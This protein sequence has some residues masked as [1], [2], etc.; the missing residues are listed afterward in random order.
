MAEY[1][2]RLMTK[3][4][5]GTSGAMGCCT[6]YVE[7]SI[8]DCQMRFVSMLSDDG[9][10]YDEF[11]VELPKLVQKF[12]QSE[13]ITKVD[14]PDKHVSIFNAVREL[15]S[16]AQLAKWAENAIKDEQQGENKKANNQWKAIKAV[17]EHAKTSGVDYCS[18]TRGWENNK[19]AA[20]G[21]QIM[22]LLEKNLQETKNHKIKS[23]IFNLI[24]EEAN[25]GEC[26]LYAIPSNYKSKQNVKYA[27]ENHQEFVN[28]EL[29]TLTVCW[30]TIEPTEELFEDE[31]LEEESNISHNDFTPPPGM[32]QELDLNNPNFDHWNSDE[33]QN[34]AEFIEDLLPILDK[35]SKALKYEYCKVI[36][37]G[38]SNPLQVLGSMFGGEPLNPLKTSAE[39]YI[40]WYEENF[41]RSENFEITGRESNKTENN[42]SAIERKKVSS[43]DK[44]L[45]PVYLEHLDLTSD[46]NPS[47]K[48]L[49]SLE[50]LSPN[51]KNTKPI[52]VGIQ[53]NFEGLDRV[54]GDDIRTARQRE[55]VQNSLLGD[56]FGGFIS[57][58]RLHWINDVQSFLTNIRA[59]LKPDGI[60]I[61]NFVGGNSLKNLRKS[62][63]DAETASGFKHSSHIS[64]FIHFDH[65]PMLLSQ[66][67]FAEGEAKIIASNIVEVNKEQ[68]KAKNILIT[69]GS[70]V[71]EIPNIKIDKEF[72]VSSTGALK[73]SKVP[74]NLIVVG[75][76][77][78]GLELGSVWRRL[79]AKVTVIEYAP[80]IVPMLEKEI[81]TQFMK[82]QQKQGI[83]FKLNTKVLLAEVKSAKVNLTIEEGG[84]SSVVASDVVLMAVGRKAYTQNLGLE[85]VGIIT[86]KQGRIEINDRFQTAISNIYAIGDVVKGA[87]LAHKAEEEAVAAVEIMAGQAGT[88]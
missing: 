75:G 22:K 88:C 42:V 55:L 80:S 33:F 63:I 57:R 70:S 23:E 21:D 67:G 87:M 62:L 76:G 41:S 34:L 1:G 82:L 31:S 5:D 29:E 48:S 37:E 83:E 78:I 85:T 68:I 58:P 11:L 50:P 73:L 6:D 49:L 43:N 12:D 17:L 45:K 60:F 46:L 10:Y 9:P 40:K 39:T 64:P 84:K 18:L 14:Y 52:V 74:E 54:K 72:I 4:Y 71:I 36:T 44:Q 3:I 20:Q 56:F 53:E 61:G 30:A 19:G 81:A 28:D 38:T 16:Y 47:E 24:L 59:F 15:E 65:V 86:D 79:G 35:E 66:A 77:Y 2:W 32:P 51:N 25:K 8:S 7:R 27:A 26:G 13:I 69:T